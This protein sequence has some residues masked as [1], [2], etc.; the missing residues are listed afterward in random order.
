MPRPNRFQR[1]KKPRPTIDML[2]YRCFFGSYPVKRMYREYGRKA[3][4][5]V[6][7]GMA[8]TILMMDPDHKLAQTWAKE[9]PHGQNR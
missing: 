3:S 5:R 2:A 1:P 8:Q 7:S 9:H 6:L 4:N